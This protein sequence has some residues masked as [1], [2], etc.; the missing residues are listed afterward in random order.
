MRN[1]KTPKPQNP[2]TPCHINT[3]IIYY[4]IYSQ[5]KKYESQM[6]KEKNEKKTEKE[7]QA[8]E[9]IIIEEPAYPANM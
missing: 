7:T 1:P 8:K 5:H 3:W 4:I 2:K 9:V 6:V